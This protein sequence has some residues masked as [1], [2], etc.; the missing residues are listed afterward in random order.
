M[1]QYNAAIKIAKQ[2]AQYLVAL[3]LPSDQTLR[4]TPI[5]ARV[6]A[7]ITDWSIAIEG[8]GANSDKPGEWE[9]GLIILRR[10]GAAEGTAPVVLANLRVLAQGAAA[11]AVLH[12]EN[13]VHAAYT[14]ALFAQLEADQNGAASAA[15]QTAAPAPGASTSVASDSVAPAGRLRR[16]LRW[17]TAYKFRALAVA[18][19]GSAVVM[20]AH[21]YVTKKPEQP[22]F[23]GAV[24]AEDQAKLEK[25]IRERVRNAA[26]EDSNIPG[27][28]GQNVAIGTMR[29]MGLEPG[30]ANTGC[31]VGVKR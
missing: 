16:C 13:A 25:D 28:D 20:I 10:A 7:P 1:T 26:R 21:G 5:L 24:S 11:E 30:K 22:M 29:A 18:L 31:L 27:L 4:V 14:E 19:A 23:M 8:Q 12:L 3:T 2:G 17:V 15:V 6:P 9:E